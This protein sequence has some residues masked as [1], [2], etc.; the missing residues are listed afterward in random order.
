[1]TGSALRRDS[2]AGVTLVELIVAISISG[3]IIAAITN[4]IFVGFKT[5]DKT[6]DRLAESHNTQLVANYFPADVGNSYFPDATRDR[7]GG[8]SFGAVG[9]PAGC[10]G[11]AA[12]STN[13]VVLP[14]TPLR[15]ESGNVVSYP[16]AGSVS[17][18]IEG[19]T[20]PRTLV[21]YE[22]GASGPAGR[23]AVAT[24]V[25]TAVAGESGANL[26]RIVSITVT[27]ISGR[28]FQVKGHPRTPQESVVLAPTTT[29]PPDAPPLPCAILSSTLLP[30]ASVA[31]VALNPDTMDLSSDVTVSIDTEG[32][33]SSPLTVTLNPGIVPDLPFTQD[34][35]RSG[36]TYSTTLSAT[37]PAW[38]A[39]SKTLTIGQ[40]GGVP[41]GGTSPVLT[42]TPA[43][44]TVLSPIEVAPNPVALANTPANT[45]QNPV[46]VSF[47]TAGT[48]PALR[49]RFS[50]GATIV[51]ANLTAG[52]GG[53]WSVTLSASTYGWTAGAKPV[54]IEPVAGGSVVNP[55]FSFTVNPAPPLP[56]TAVSPLTLNPT[57]VALG[58]GANSGT[59]RRAV[60]LSVTTS[61]T[62]TNLSV[63]Y[64][65]GSVAR[66]DT[67]TSANGTTWTGS[68]DRT[69]T[70]GA[71]TAG[72]HV[73][74][75][76]GTTTSPTATLT[77]NP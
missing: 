13:L 4:A 66:T 43:P 35:T 77:V 12:E 10:T 29:A 57:T 59:L 6:T 36:T 51:T 55:A 5:T 61:G 69:A 67:L 25:D 38:K 76:V 19:T 8:I 28:T 34:L 44:C 7:T 39:G 46:F 11:L 17:Y 54:T 52:A 68:L 32:D 26:Q 58:N 60:D 27:E 1:M 62:C 45:L 47:T 56:C 42:V 74:T 15:T 14:N 20:P 30:S 71:W 49:L 50:P 48:C 16:A 70:G 73:I 9:L 41:V 65:N 22:C 3:I 72:T 21:R 18:W 2:E 40:F 63:T 24:N 33:C 23:V 53:T 37:I 31:L 64:F 75:L